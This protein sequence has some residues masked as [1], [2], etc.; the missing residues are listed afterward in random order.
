MDSVPAVLAGMYDTRLVVLSVVIAM[1]TAEAAL[2]LAGRVSL[3][4]GLARCWWLSGGAAAMGIGI[5]STHYIGMLAFRLPVIVLYD[6]PMRNV[7]HH[8]RGTR[9]SGLGLPHLLG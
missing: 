1:V 4:R 7:E 8:C 5:W 9:H 6:R 2:D 3:A